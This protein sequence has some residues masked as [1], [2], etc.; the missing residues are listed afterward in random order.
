MAG[1]LGRA[2]AFSFYPTKNLSALGDAG[3]V[4]TQDAELAARLREIRQYGWRQRN[5]SE[6]AGVNSRMDELQAAVL[7]VK[8]QTLRGSI[9]QRRRLA[10][11][12]DARLGGSRVVMLPVVRGGCEHA[13]HQF[14]VRAERRDEL[15]RHLTQGSIPVSVH[16]PVPLHR[17]RG[18]GGSV[19]PLPESERAAATVISLPV[20][21]YLS[22][23]AVGAVCAA[24]ERFDHA[25][26]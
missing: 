18:F 21:P 16:Y 6:R 7:R 1:T 2:A 12:Y 20:H 22:E 23:E 24:I 10:A 5:I 14:V 26:G 15:V 13:Y 3:A 9:Q 4:A 8:L 25:C 19:L 17:Q 11:E